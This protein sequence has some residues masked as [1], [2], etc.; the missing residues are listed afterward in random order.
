MDA[1][2][3]VLEHYRE[4]SNFIE[5]ILSVGPQSYNNKD[6]ILTSVVN[7][8]HSLHRFEYCLRRKEGLREICLLVKK[9]ASNIC[10]QSEVQEEEVTKKK[11]KID[12]GDGPQR[13]SAIESTIVP[14]GKLK[15]SDVAGLS[16]AKKLLKEAVIMPLKYPH[17]FVGQRKPWRRILLFGP[18][19]T[20]K[21]RI[22][23]A[24]S[25]EVESPFYSVSSSDLLSSWFGESEKLIKE[26]FRNARDNPGRSVIFID[27]IDGLC[28]KR[29]S[30]EQEQTRRIKTELLKQ[31]EGVETSDNSDVFVLGST[32]CPWELDTA[33][34]RRFE[35]R[36]FIPLPDAET[37]R[38]LFDIHL[39]SFPIKLTTDEWEKILK[40]S[41]GYSG[42]DIATCIAD[43]LFEPIRELESSCYWRWNTDGKTVSP[44]TQSEVGA[45]QI[46]FESIP[47]DQV[48]ARPVEYRDVEKAL[49]KNHSTICLE[50]LTKYEEFTSSFG[51]R[52]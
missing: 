31:M 14:Q 32:N 27:E 1:N 38:E 24:L 12:V 41:E 52:A 21:S 50:E 25:S 23:K 49:E 11:Q 30:N 36:I 16:M 2:E 37:R 48:K 47:A 35:K 10:E 40:K 39:N 46:G 19:G 4:I 20:G 9:Y 29:N 44:C 13:R 5:C 34:L 7:K 15:F 45:V 42:S 43:A 18:P 17:L 28:R 8:L 3:S 26:L 51:Q 6:N 22:A 33:F